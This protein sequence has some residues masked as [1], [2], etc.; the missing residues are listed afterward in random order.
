MTDQ[1]VEANRLKRVRRR[2][3]LRSRDLQEP[4]DQT[5]ET[6]D[7]PLHI[8]DSRSDVPSGPDQFDGERNPRQGPTHPARRIVAVTDLIRLST[9]LS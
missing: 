6:A 1:I 7:L 9:S 5:G 8:A 3:A 2:I 4:V